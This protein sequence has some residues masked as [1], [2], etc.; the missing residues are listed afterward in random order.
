[1]EDKI[2]KKYGDKYLKWLKDNNLTCV[3]TNDITKAKKLKIAIS[4]YK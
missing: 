1:M 3:F 2:Q 4:E